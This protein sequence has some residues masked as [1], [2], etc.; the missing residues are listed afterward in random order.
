M[1]SIPVMA[2]GCLVVRPPH[3]H[4]Q[5]RLT[6]HAKQAIPSHRNTLLPERRSNQVMQLARANTGLSC[7]M[8]THQR[9]RALHVS[10]PPL[11]TMP[12]LVVGLATDPKVL[13]SP[14]YAYTCQA[15]REDLPEGFF[16]TR[17]P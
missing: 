4:Q 9:Q 2:I 1:P 6:Q 8:A 15:L 10:L 3:G 16:T 5:T 17:T 11:L 14:C 7:P 12:C 13:A